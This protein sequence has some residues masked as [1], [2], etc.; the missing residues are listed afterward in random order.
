RRF[1]MLIPEAVQLV[2]HAAAMRDTGPIF[3]LDMG[4]PI[5]VLD[6]ARN[7]IRLSGFVPDEEIPI[8]FIGVRPGEKLS[9]ELVEDG[10][11]AQATGLE[12]VLKVCAV[13]PQ[14][15][16]LQLALPRL[17]LAAERGRDD[18]VLA[19]LCALIPSFRPAAAPSAETRAQ[20]AHAAVGD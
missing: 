19:T 18:D 6:L 3:A 4:E 2:L 12:K 14:V 13:T 7:L 8:T 15:D 20:Y 11:V 16:D 17:E 5:K 10:E 9:E 1:F